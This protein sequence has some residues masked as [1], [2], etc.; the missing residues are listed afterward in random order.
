[1]SSLLIRNVRCNGSQQDVL[2]TG[3][4]FDRFAP[5]CSVE[6]PPGARVLDGSGKAL[7][8][9]FFNAHTHHA[10]SL[11]RG[12]ADD[13]PL[14]EWLNDHIWPAEARM[15]PDHMLAGVR[16][17]ALESIRSGSVFF[18]DMYFNWEHCAP[19]VEEMG[20]RAVVGD[21][22]MS[23]TPRDAVRR[24]FER[25]GRPAT[26]SGRIRWSLDPHAVYTADEALLRETA[27]AARA[28]G[29]IVHIHVSE[30]EREVRDCFAAH[31][32]SPV[33][34][35]H[36]LGLLSP[37]LVAAHA[38][39]LSDRDLGLLADSGAAVVHN[40]SSNMKLGS[41]AFPAAQVLARSIPLLVGTDGPASN[42]S[43]DM[44]AETRLAA[45]LAKLPGDPAV[46]PAPKALE[47]ATLAAARVFGID[48]GVLAPGHLA[49]ALVVDLSDPRLVPDSDFVSNWVYAAD[50]ASIVHVLCDGRLLME[51]RVVPHQDEILESARRAARDLLAPHP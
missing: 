18:N 14:H 27:E 28:T 44:H 29:A 39:H 49:D 41:G 8:P 35:L 10:M 19:A 16:L 34:W 3:N 12:Y 45:L 22:L 7:V 17:A 50:N 24:S 25:A 33:E 2:V 1:M 9:P 47:C 23:F 46:L 32:C 6:P 30:T 21:T 40:P 43:V 42:N 4:K 20:L 15:T 36:R 38:V 26:P 11:L 51:N 31:G 5:P 48:S 37:N 13:L